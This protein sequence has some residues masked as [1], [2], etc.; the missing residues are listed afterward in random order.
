MT[1]HPTLKVLGKFFLAGSS[2][3]AFAGQLPNFLVEMARRI[4]R[5]SWPT[6]PR[7]CPGG[8]GAR[9]WS[10]PCLAWGGAPAPWIDPGLK[11]LIPALLIVFLALAAKFGSFEAYLQ[12]LSRQTYS[13]LLPALGAGYT[14]VMLIFQLCRTILWA[15]YRPYPL[16]AG[17]L[18]HP[19]RDH[20]G[21]QRRG[22]GGEGHL[23]RGGRRLSGREAGNHLHRR[24]LPG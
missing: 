19:D 14:L 7:P 10:R 17:P 13:S 3:A 2:R 4:R 15:R 12:L 20:P 16:A 22:H 18:A 11:V 24:R 5:N 1:A 21:L 9:R 6:A 23:F 8:R